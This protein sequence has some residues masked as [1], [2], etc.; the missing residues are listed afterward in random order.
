MRPTSPQYSTREVAA[1]NASG[2]ELRI[3]AACLPARKTLDEFVFDHQP[4]IRRCGLAPNPGGFAPHHL[5]PFSVSR[6][7]RAS[8]DFARV[9]RPFLDRSSRSADR[10]HLRGPHICR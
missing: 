10:G 8:P 6:Q 1:R 5:G 2:A 9:R 7:N 3:P 4:G